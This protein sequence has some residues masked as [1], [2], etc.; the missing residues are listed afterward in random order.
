MPSA[1]HPRLRPRPRLHPGTPT[2]QTLRVAAAA[3]ILAA[4]LAGASTAHAEL[5]V[6]FVLDTTGSMSAEIHEV[7]ERV[8]Q[9]AV[10]YAKARAGERL[11]FGIVAFRD[12][13]DE[14]VTRVCPLTEDVGIAGAFLGSLRADGGGDG[15]ESVVAALAAALHEI[16][17]DLSDDTE[18]LIFLIGDA[19][20]HLDY[21]GE[22]TPAELLAEA[23]ASRI[24]INTIGCRSLPPEGVTFFRTVAYAT[25]GSYQ[26]IGRVQG[27][28]PG[29]LAEALE[30]TVTASAEGAAAGGREVDLAWSRHDD[31]DANGILVRQA[32]PLGTPQSREGDALAPCSL[33]VLLPPGFGLDGE[34]RV[35]LGPAGLEVELPLAHGD[36]GRDLFT[37]EECPPLTTPVHVLLGGH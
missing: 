31:A 33:E 14:Y 32:G 2:S 20:P 4:A 5:D 8:Q 3:A 15:P 22:P 34:P 6:V 10:S 12:R 19:P 21:A 26:H 36:G 17:W 11:R 35:R 27:A 37:L 1:A 7:Q 25:E 24:V 9:L 28:Q 29:A 13:G 16:S 23:R 18:R 30:G